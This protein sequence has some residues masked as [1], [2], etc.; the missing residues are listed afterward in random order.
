M[1][2]FTILIAVYNAEA[3][4][5]QCLDSLLAQ[6][7]QSFEVI[8]ID[9]CSTDGSA[10]VVQRYMARDERIRLLRTPANSGQAVA[11]N[12]GL[13]QARG[14]LTTMVDADDWLATDCLQRMWE[15]FSAEPD[16]DAVVFRLVFWEEGRTWYS[17]R[18]ERLPRRLTGRDACRYS[19]DWTLH[20]CYAVRT[21]IHRRYPYD[22]SC[23]LF[24]DDNTSRQH[25]L[26]SRHVA[27]S[28]GCYYYRQHPG[29]STRQATRRS[30][31]FIAANDSLRAMLEH[32]GADADMLSICEDYVWRN[33]VGLWRKW[34]KASSLSAEEAE[35]VAALFRRSYGLIKSSRLPWRTKLRPCFFRCATYGLFSRW[36]R[37]LMLRQK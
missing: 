21:D 10:D 28:D 35:E 27:L 2:R 16:N 4:L 13:E 19:I 29:N 32:E 15:A 8:C 3:W 17:D 23:R 31:D 30:F 18:T 20:G 9:D 24:S 12:L 37:L 5:P 6:T 14:V 11:R 22:T 26:H 34:Q 1:I 33:S 7:E 25:Y 36:Q